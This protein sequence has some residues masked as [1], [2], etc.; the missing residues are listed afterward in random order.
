MIYELMYLY[1]IIRIR[2]N[3]I[4]VKCINYYKANIYNLLYSALNKNNNKVKLDKQKQRF[5]Y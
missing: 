4:R 2:I 5:I 3:I 1:F